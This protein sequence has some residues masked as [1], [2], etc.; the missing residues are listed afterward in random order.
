[1]YIVFG[2]G[3]TGKAVAN[4]FVKEGIGFCIYN[5][6]AIDDIAVQKFIITQLPA[7]I[8]SI[9]AIITSPGISTKYNVES[10]F[11]QDAKQSGVPIVSDIQL[12]MK[13]FPQKKY[14]AITGT[15][16]KSTITTLTYEIC[17][18]AGLRV[19]LSGNIGVS[20]FENAT[21]CDVCVLE[22]SSFQLEITH[23]VQ[24]DVSLV[25]NITADHLDR[26]STLESYAYEKLRIA[27][28][29]KQCIINETVTHNYKNIVPFSTEKTVDG[30]YFQNGS[31]Y[32]KGVK[33]CVIPKTPNPQNPENIISAFALTH[34]FGVD[35][36]KITEAISQFNGIEHRLE[37]VCEKNGVKYYNDSK[38]T[39]LDSTYNALQ[40]LNGDILLIAGGKL[41][42]D[43]SGVF[44]KKEFQTVKMMALIGSSAGKIKKELQ[45]HNEKNSYNIKHSLCGNLENAVK[46]LTQEAKKYKNP[47]ILLSPFCKSFDQFSN[48]EQRGKKFKEILSLL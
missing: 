38:A 17:K 28:L 26:Y 11:I 39:N 44:A 48:F 6:T 24:F 7:D 4:F 14:I 34:L 42:D 19:A 20:P 9:K 40:I 2:Y 8:S 33:L 31:I 3:K 46:L 30:Y 29:S 41:V 10:K 32:F 35:V 47:I 15:N 5:E 45:E 22:I 37:F 43:I 13:L 12:F 27:E 36:N 1:M 16:G 23:G 18:N 21:D 25:S